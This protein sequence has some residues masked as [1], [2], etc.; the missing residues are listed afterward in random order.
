MMA[1]ATASTSLV[2]AQAVFTESERFALAGFLAGYRGLTREACTLDLRQFTGWCQA[3]RHG[4]VAGLVRSQEGGERVRPAEGSV[5][6]C[7]V[8]GRQRSQDGFVVNGF[9]VSTDAEVLDDRLVVVPPE[10]RHGRPNRFRRQIH[11]YRAHQ[12]RLCR[13]NE[14]PG[15]RRALSRLPARDPPARSMA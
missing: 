2:P 8:R 15:A 13:S 11:P 12:Q 14:D 3:A 9:V 7:L 10:H 1:A 4:H 5:D 6:A